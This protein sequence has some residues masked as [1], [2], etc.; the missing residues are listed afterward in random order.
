MKLGRRP[1][2]YLF[3]LLPLLLLTSISYASMGS[4]TTCF[5]FFLLLAFLI[6]AMLAQGKSPLVGFDISVRK[7]P[8]EIKSTSY[9]VKSYTSGG[10]DTV[11][12][13]RDIEGGGTHATRGT[14]WAANKLAKLGGKI[15][16]REDWGKEGG[17]T[18]NL[19]QRGGLYAITGGKAGGGYAGNAERERKAKE[20]YTSEL[21]GEKKTA[22]EQ[23]D[24]SVKSL[25]QM[26]TTGKGLVVAYSASDPNKKRIKEL[27]KKRKSGIR[28][29]N[30]ER[31]E[32]S[33]LTTKVAAGT[34]SGMRQEVE[35]LSERER[36]GKLKPA[37]AK[38]LRSLRTELTALDQR[39]QQL[40]T[41]QKRY[42]LLSERASE[43]AELAAVL[44]VREKQFKDK[45]NALD[46]VGSAKARVKM[47]ASPFTLITAGAGLA[48][49]STYRSLSKANKKERDKLKKEL[50]AN[51]DKHMTKKER[52]RLNKIKEKQQHGG[53]LN[54]DED[55]LI[56]RAR[57]QNL[58]DGKGTI[59]SIFNP[60]GL[61][62]GKYFKRLVK[63]NV[64][65]I[66]FAVWET[67]IPRLGRWIYGKSEARTKGGHLKSPKD[68]SKILDKIDKLRREIVNS[69]YISV[70]EKY[71]KLGELDMMFADLDRLVRKEVPG[72]KGLPIELK[73]EI[74]KGEREMGRSLERM[75]GSQEALNDLYNERTNARAKRREIRANKGDTT[76]VN[77]KIKDLNDKIIS[78]NEDL[79]S[80]TRNLRKLL[81]EKAPEM[82]AEI[83]ETAKE[84]KALNDL[85]NQRTKAEEERREIRKK[86]GNT[87]QIDIKIKDLNE[88][89][90]ETRISRTAALRHHVAM[91]QM[92]G[93]TTNFLDRTDE[94]KDTA[95]RAA[96]RSYAIIEDSKNAEVSS[97]SRFGWL[98]QKSLEP[99][100][101]TQNLRQ[102]QDN[103]ENVANPKLI[104]IQRLRRERTQIMS[105]LNESE[106]KRDSLY[107]R[108]KRLRAEIENLSSALK[109]LKKDPEATPNQIKQLDDELF[110][111]RR[112]LRELELFL[113]D[114]E[115]LIEDRKK[116]IE[117][118]KDNANALVNSILLEDALL[119][120][121]QLDKKIKDNKLRGIKSDDKTLKLKRELREASA[122]TKRYAGKKEEAYSDLTRKLMTQTGDPAPGSETGL[123]RELYELNEL[124]R[125]RKDT[126]RLKDTGLKREEFDET[127]KYI[128]ARRNL[129]VAKLYMNERILSGGEQMISF[130]EA[131][132][133]DK[134]FD[135]A[136][137]KNSV[138]NA[139]LEAKMR[140][141]I[142]KL[143]KSELQKDRGLSWDQEVENLEKFIKGHEDKLKEAKKNINMPNV[144]KE[145]L[146]LKKTE[147]E[148][149]NTAI[150]HRWAMLLMRE[151]AIKGS[152]A[153]A[154]E[155]AE[156]RNSF[157]KR[158]ERAPGAAWTGLG[159][160]LGAEKKEEFSEEELKTLTQIE[161]NERRR[162]NLVNSLISKDVKTEL[163]V[164]EKRYKS[165]EKDARDLADK[166]R[167]ITKGKIY[168]ETEEELDNTLSKYNI[169][170]K[171]SR[172][173]LTEVRKQMPEIKKEIKNLEGK[174]SKL[175]AGSDEY[176]EIESNINA[177][178]NKL[179]EA[180][181]KFNESYKEWRNY[182]KESDAIFEPEQHR[183]LTKPGSER[184]EQEYFMDRRKDWENRIYGGRFSRFS[185]FASKLAANAAEFGFKH[186]G[187]ALGAAA[188]LAPL[189]LAIPVVGPVAFLVSEGAAATY[190]AKT[191]WRKKEEWVEHGY[192][193]SEGFGVVA[194]DALHSQRLAS[195]FTGRGSGSPPKTW[196]EAWASQMT[197]SEYITRGFR[198][199]RYGE[200]EPDKDKLLVPNEGLPWY[201]KIAKAP[202]DSI[203]ATIAARVR[204]F[205]VWSQYHAESK[206]LALYILENPKVIPEVEE[207]VTYQYAKFYGSV[208]PLIHPKAALGMMSLNTPFP[209][210]AK[211]IVLMRGKT[212]ETYSPGTAL[213]GGDI[214]AAK[215]RFEKNMARQFERNMARFK[216]MHENR[217]RDRTI[218]S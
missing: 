74:A 48:A 83:Q 157:R 40:T 23:T 211:H 8:S 53:K 194:R 90:K 31:Q 135:D 21:K 11:S 217:R 191:I 163:E 54:A 186:G 51:A 70:S 9:K 101:N 199:N 169:E 114:K 95:L 126:K 162:E 106:R 158:M 115:K 78:K 171:T 155:L 15:A 45:I 188:V 123:H 137:A 206:D 154:E 38:K 130:E 36:S 88:K 28:L 34:I 81:E 71:R 168:R 35:R 98:L 30:S 50:G 116:N 39:Y 176:K 175:T 104:E 7:P 79:Q 183:K 3:I 63:A 147:K 102:I 99:Y 144:K 195:H 204:K 37:E 179:P 14:G 172:E 59:S 92:H 160:K 215:K 170:V 167:S 196:T 19:S 73:Q 57:Y 75:K 214:E 72:S 46:S 207:R 182:K 18:H 111:K 52:K 62:K 69:Q 200:V 94:A 67:P 161:I 216:E 164:L 4:I 198:V 131:K 148:L 65:G 32:L 5:P 133:Y 80:H 58:R 218:G 152:I 16:G 22:K 142:I 107:D 212:N 189:S 43:Q 76:D 24:K 208:E 64:R 77:R 140:E 10:F 141:M 122:L 185:G 89:I 96:A 108:K 113:E 190:G 139:S 56:K 117:R 118:I 138:V 150:T 110:K 105:Q 202:F 173:N 174:K 151:D 120:Q 149:R 26:L 84:N 146:D 82:R 29:S 181:R 177:L 178:S 187:K 127:V 180:Q 97:G 17:F 134:K 193:N 49:Q 93:W 100:Q 103:M 209:E 68:A 6:A 55:K 145:E 25:R 44:K 203:G 2:N 129:V 20:Q 205:T 109:N 112:E 136:N 125:A 13:T 184:V 66:G 87:E 47:M 159:E 85:Y 42:N 132:K 201:I 124:L 143:D 166:G 210:Y 165:L 12:K 91:R 197:G 1:S 192:P 86:K 128:E 41:N 27:E 213:L 119:V 61:S 153:P 156:H 60:M 121:R 33:D